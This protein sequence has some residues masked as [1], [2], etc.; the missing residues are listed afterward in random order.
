M[1]VGD[2]ADPERA[3]DAAL[4]GVFGPR[5][6]AHGAAP[7]I[8][9]HAAMYDRFVEGA[10]ARVA[11]LRQGPPLEAA[12]D[13]GAIAAPLLEAITE[14]VDDALSRG[15]RAPVGGG[16]RADL[17]GTFFAPTILVDVDR[18]MRIVREDVRG[19]AMVI[20]KMHDAEALDLAAV[21]P[22]HRFRVAISAALHPVREHT[23]DLVEST[24]R[25]LHARG[26]RRRARAAVDVARNL[27]HVVREGRNP[28]DA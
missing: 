10:T 25:V 15:A 20:V 5:G 9:V 3:L 7:R 12:V 27:V 6:R 4:L 22:P 24:V 23:Y 14:L 18:A 11:A 26:I 1:I 16:R 8:H 13:T 21:S 28:P 2:D 19:P 17:P